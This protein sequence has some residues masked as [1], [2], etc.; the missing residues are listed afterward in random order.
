MKAYKTFM[1][2]LDWEYEN[3]LCCST[4]EKVRFRIG[5]IC[6]IWKSFEAMRNLGVITEAHYVKLMETAQ[7]YRDELRNLEKDLR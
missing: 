7:K 3:G 6:G 4:T 5:K 1:E 2:L